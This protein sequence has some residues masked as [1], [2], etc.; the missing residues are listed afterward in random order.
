MSKQFILRA[1]LIVAL[2]AFLV[3]QLAAQTDREVKGKQGDLKEEYN[4][5]QEKNLIIKSAAE[6]KPR[7]T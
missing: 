6:D 5:A 3:P 4:A 7:A 2:V 1:F